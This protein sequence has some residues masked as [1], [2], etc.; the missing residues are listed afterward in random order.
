MSIESV[1]LCNHLILCYL[2]LLLPSIFPSIRV[3]SNEAALHIKWT[4]SAS[5]S[6]PSMNIQGRFPFGWMDGNRWMFAWM[7]DEWMLS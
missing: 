4:V 3:F 7:D 6:A 2:L 1:M 5:V